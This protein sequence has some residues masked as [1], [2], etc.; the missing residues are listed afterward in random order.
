MTDTPPSRPSRRLVAGLVLYVAAFGIVGT[1]W[2][3]SRAGWQTAPG[4]LPPAPPVASTGPAAA[5]PASAAA[6]R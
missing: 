6:S 1:W 4:A 2:L 3:G 5:A